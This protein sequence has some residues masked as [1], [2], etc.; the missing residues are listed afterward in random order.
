VRWD[1]KIAPCLGLLHAHRTYLNGVERAVSE[2][3]VGDIRSDGLF[4]A[5]SSGEYARFREKVRSFEFAPCHLCGGCGLLEKN[6]EDC[7]GNTFPAC[8]ACLWAQ[9]VIQCP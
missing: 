4:R 6:E 7:Y 8:G 3:L 9:G 1:G 5:W 2:Y